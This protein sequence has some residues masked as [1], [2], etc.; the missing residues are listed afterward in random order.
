[1]GPSEHGESVRRPSDVAGILGPGDRLPQEP[2]RLTVV[3]LVAGDGPEIR[4]GLR[5]DQRCAIG[6]VH[7]LGQQDSRPLVATPEE[8]DVAELGP[9]L[10]DG[11]AVAMT[12]GNVICTS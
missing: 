11:L 5:G 12:Q 10:R 1:V 4:G 8:V 9:G 3:T 6:E 7:G 2:E